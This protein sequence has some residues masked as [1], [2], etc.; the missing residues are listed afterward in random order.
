MFQSYLN[1]GIVL[2][3]SANKCHLSKTIHGTV[4]HQQNSAGTHQ[5]LHRYTSNATKTRGKLGGSGL[6]I[7]FKKGI[8]LWQCNQ[9]WSIPVDEYFNIPIHSSFELWEVPLISD[10]DHKV[11]HWIGKLN[12]FSF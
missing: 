3:G 4:K 6:K 7:I 5:V 11:M 1:Y 12:A 2:W 10:C 8:R 9:I